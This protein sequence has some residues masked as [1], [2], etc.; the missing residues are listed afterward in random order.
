MHHTNRP[1]HVQRVAFA[2]KLQVDRMCFVVS[3]SNGQARFRQLVSFWDEGAVRHVDSWLC[4]VSV[5]VHE[6][7]DNK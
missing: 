6:V 5:K 2:V 1:E 7:F 4:Y 3:G